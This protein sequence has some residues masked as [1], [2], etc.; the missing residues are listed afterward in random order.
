MKTGEGITCFFREERINPQPLPE[1]ARGWH[2]DAFDS[3][4]SS[5]KQ[6]TFSDCEFSNKKANAT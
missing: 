2:N 1:G 3:S 5:M 6:T 4:R